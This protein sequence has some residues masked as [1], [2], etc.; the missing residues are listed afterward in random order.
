M[1]PRFLSK[2]LCVQHG[3]FTKSVW[4]LKMSHLNKF[5]DSLK[6][7]FFC[8]VCIFSFFSVCF[9]TDLFVSVVS[10]RVWNTETNRNKPKKIVFGFAKQTE[11]Q[12][13]QIEFRF[14]SVRTENFFCLFRGHP[15][16]EVSLRPRKLSCRETFPCY[17]HPILREIVLGTT[18]ICYRDFQICRTNCKDYNGFCYVLFYDPAGKIL[19]Q[20]FSRKFLR[21]ETFSENFCNFLHAFMQYAKNVFAKILQTYEQENCRFNP[22]YII[23]SGSV[24]ASDFSF[25]KTIYSTAVL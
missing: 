15:S 2:M 7:R 8:F 13:K 3:D 20:Y 24:T 18:N 25:Q 4:G 1:H 21:N 12:P 11:N 16:S 10:K 17:Q 6:T 9:E 19:L 5:L 22:I 14:V 23:T